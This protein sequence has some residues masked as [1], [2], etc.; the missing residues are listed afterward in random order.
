MKKNIS[1]KKNGASKTKTTSARLPAKLVSPDALQ[2]ILRPR[3]FDQ[4]EAHEASCV[5]IHGPPGSGKTTL[6]A[7]YL[8]SRK[9][10]PI[11]YQVDKDDAEI[12][13][14]F[15]FMSMLFN[16]RV[17]RAHQVPA[18]DIENREDWQGFARRF[19]RAML[20]GLTDDDVLVFENI[21][22]ADGALDEVLGIFVS[23]AGQQRIILT[24][25]HRP[26][27]AF[28]DQMIKQQLTELNADALRFDLPET[29]ELLNKTANNAADKASGKGAAAA[30]LAPGEIERLHVIADG[31]GAGIVLL[32]SQP[33]IELTSGRFGSGSHGKLFD[34]FSKVVIEKMIP[35]ARAVLEA[36]AFLP[37]FDADLAT[38]A[39]GNPRASEILQNLHRN[40]LFVERRIANKKVVFR[41]H[42]LLAE[43]LRER[44]NLS[45]QGEIRNG[46][47]RQLAMVR[48][49]NLLTACGRIEASIP[50]LMDGGDHHAAAINILKLA[51]SIIAEGRIEQLA[52]WISALP[53]SV[54]AQLPW[55]DYWLGLSLA[56]TDEVASRR[57]LTDVYLRFKKSDDQLGC[58][59]C[60]AIIVSN[61]ETGWQG[62]DGFDYWNDALLSNWETDISF[63]TPESELRA[64]VGL[65]SVQL[66]TTP[67]EH[68]FGD[69][70][71]RV[72]TLI[73]LAK[74]VNAQL[75]AAI[76]VMEW[77]GHGRE[78]ERALLF[79]NF[80]AHEVRM[81][82]ASPSRTARWHWTMCMMHMAAAMVLRKPALM[83]TSHKHRATAK[84]IAEEHDLS[85]IKI[86]L[87]H[88]EAER[89]IWTRDVDNMRL[90]LDLIKPA[91]Q[92]G[93]VRQIVSHLNLRANLALL[94]GEAEDAWAEVCRMLAMTRETHFP[95]V[96]SSAYYV[97]AANTLAYLGR[98]DEAVAHIELLLPTAN[99]G[100]RQ[101]LE[102]SIL[103]MH[104]MQAANQSEPIDSSAVALFFCDLREKRM[105]EYGRLLRPLLAR[106]CVVA[107]S[108]DIETEFVRS[109][110]LHRKFLPPTPQGSTRAPANWPWPLRIEAF[111]EF[112]V[113]LADVPLTFDG[114]SQ[115]KPLELLKMIAS[116]QS[117]SNDGLGPRVQHVVDELWPD[118]EAK[119]P[120]GSFEIALHRL[121]K[122]IA[123]DEALV[124]A[125]GRIS[126]NQALVW[127]DV[128]EFD[129]LARRALPEDAMR[130]LALYTG[131]LLGSANFVWAAAPRERLAALYTAIVDRSAAELENAGDH[132]AAIALYELAL[133]QDSLIEPFYRG[134]MRC[135]AARRETTEALRSYR[136]CRELL[137]AV[138]GAAPTAETEALK[139]Q[140]AAQAIS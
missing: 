135:H 29:A 20:M 71:D 137:F 11:W 56:P 112:R 4:I 50:L 39:S 75:S 140:I 109:F 67:F 80:V 27:P 107:L 79:E 49:G 46:A 86:S 65:L 37:D 38:A 62:F 91:L 134:L 64:I 88:A 14:F 34:Y 26:P 43:T 45:E 133:Q 41:F 10:T 82:Q 42:A 52:N 58:L 59:S 55:L 5:W 96:H 114:K 47:A 3:L 131:P 117:A 18:I 130:A 21:H 124:L 8:Q 63:P 110:I 100:N 31:W 127:W 116:L 57:V 101:I 84:Q 15:F 119:D 136:R 13:T 16:S 106:L 118:L 73:P 74:D 77:F 66:G 22:E 132:Q 95:I 12:S 44:V 23:E 69:L 93:Y 98:Y 25:H 103:F 115:K 19:F 53:N 70:P 9:L 129:T 120:Q 123:V 85:N 1:G 83:E 32:G 111:G 2:A 6:A 104:A 81:A 36:C 92:P 97:V 76:I 35:E 51:E 138:L 90:V 72:L 139:S 60:A 30:P 61:I 122:L 17:T 7:S 125:D 121:R 94:C 28:V 68:K 105:L 87:A 102:T 99:T 48:T 54:R 24:S 33:A 108:R 128:M 89:C 113:S 40:G 126:L 78:H